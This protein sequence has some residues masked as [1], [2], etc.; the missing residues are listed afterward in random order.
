MKFS[1]DA[2]YLWHLEHVGVLRRTEGGFSTPHWDL[3]K[4]AEPV[5]VALVDSGIDVG[6]PNL[7]GA[8]AAPQVDFGPRMEGAVYVPRGETINAIRRALEFD[9]PSEDDLREAVAGAM[10]DIEAHA[11]SVGLDLAQ[12]TALVQAAEGSADLEALVTACQAIL[13]ALRSPASVAAPA[14][15]P[16]LSA[17]H[18]AALEDLGLTAGE[19]AAVTEIAQTLSRGPEPIELQDPSRYFGAHGTACAGLVGGRPA[20]ADP[21]APV[22]FTALPYYGVNPYCRILS[23]ATPYSHEIRPVLNALVAAYL[24][25]AEVIL[26]PRGVPDIVARGALAASRSRNTRIDHDDPTVTVPEDQANFARLKDDAA[27]LEKVMAAIARQRYLVLAAGNEGLS[28]RVG[29]PGS[30]LVPVPEAIIVGAETSDG[31]RASYSNGA[32]LGDRVLLIVSD[33]AVTVDAD[34]FGIDPTSA[35]GSDFDF[36]PHF[37]PGAESRFSPWAPLTL[38]VRGG[39]GYAAS[40]EA[41]APDFD[42]GV[43]RGAI[44]TLFGGTSAASSICAGLVALLLQSGKLQGGVKTAAEVAAILKAEGLGPKSA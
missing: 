37:P 14:A 39:Y 23:Y 17:G 40:N 18:L 5:T 38:D 9:T 4:E 12:L 21:A 7:S 16:A 29:Y 8:I 25:G 13:D 24:S 30:K 6:H 28:D 19:T 10:A 34:G 2:F 15:A 42:D 26:M 41:D 32:D 1:R 22:F 33:D 36:T 3:A 27:L 43:D 35:D 11:A 31:R 20:E 44:Y